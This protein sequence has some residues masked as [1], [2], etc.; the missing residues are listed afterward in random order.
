[1]RSLGLTVETND[2]AKKCLYKEDELLSEKTS[3]LSRVN[4]QKEE[5]KGLMHENKVPAR[6]R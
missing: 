2:E 1:M 5:W 6:G 3:G 4:S